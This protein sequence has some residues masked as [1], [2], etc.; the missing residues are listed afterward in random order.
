[1]SQNKKDKEKITESVRTIGQSFQNM[2]QIA[3]K[4]QTWLDKGVFEKIIVTIIKKEITEVPIINKGDF[5]KV[6]F[7]SS[8]MK[9]LYRKNHHKTSDKIIKNVEYILTVSANAFEYSGWNPKY[10]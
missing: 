10:L 4:Y 6:I 2:L 1:M 7:S 9:F 8:C 3:E 5:L